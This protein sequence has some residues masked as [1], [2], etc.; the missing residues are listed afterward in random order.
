[1]IIILLALIVSATADPDF[2]A[3][4]IEKEWRKFKIFTK[5]SECTG[6]RSSVLSECRKE[7]LVPG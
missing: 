5:I 7:S 3:V 2:Y 4:K 6:H 1:M